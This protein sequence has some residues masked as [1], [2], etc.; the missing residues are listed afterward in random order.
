V[1]SKTNRFSKNKNHNMEKI[2]LYQFK[3]LKC[4]KRYLRNQSNTKPTKADYIDALQQFVKRYPKSIDDIISILKKEKERIISKRIEAK[5]KQ[6]LRELE[7][8]KEEFNQI[9]VGDFVAMRREKKDSLEFGYMRKILGFNHFIWD[10]LYRHTSKKRK[11]SYGR[12]M[13]RPIYNKPFE[14]QNEI[15][16]TAYHTY[17]ITK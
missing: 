3:K 10:R 9:K 1:I 15:V 5:K 8:E 6:L 13:T 17:V 12:F 4:L 7:L 2:T 16:K 11:D 14:V